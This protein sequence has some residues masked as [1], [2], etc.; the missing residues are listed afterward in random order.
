MSAGID[1]IV[2]AVRCRYCRRLKQL[3]RV[4]ASARVKYTD[5]WEGIDIADNPATT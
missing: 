2:V 5:I 1:E 4:L 3:Q